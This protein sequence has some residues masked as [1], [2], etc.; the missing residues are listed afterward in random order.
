MTITVTISAPPR[1][2]VRVKPGRTRRETLLR[3]TRAA[4]QRITLSVP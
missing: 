4:M 3:A 1:V 2:R